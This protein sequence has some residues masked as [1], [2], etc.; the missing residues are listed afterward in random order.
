MAVTE[1]KVVVIGI[2]EVEF[3][4][5]SLCHSIGG[6]EECFHFSVKTEEFIVTQLSGSIVFHILLGNDPG[7]YVFV[8]P[9]AH[10]PRKNYAA[11][12]R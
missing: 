5:F 1:W 11:G 4:F 10:S 8:W 7:F 2:E 6:N 9:F 12:K 3:C